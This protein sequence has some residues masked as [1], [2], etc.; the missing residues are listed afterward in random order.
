M[1]IIKAA[2]ARNRTQ[3]VREDQ[4]SQEMIKISSRVEQAIVK[5]EFSVYIDFPLG[6]KV[7]M[8]KLLEE[9]DYKFASSGNV[10]HS[11]RYQI[12][13]SWQ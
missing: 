3:N 5:G 6:L 8:L 10:A 7:E 13:I 9:Y 1:N 12:K 2:D 4:M 11:G